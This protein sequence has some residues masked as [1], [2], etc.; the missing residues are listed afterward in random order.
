MPSITAT[1]YGICRTLVLPAIFAFALVAAVLAA[2]NPQQ[3][4]RA[5]F[6]HTE[7]RRPLIFIPGLLGSRLCRP[8]PANPAEP[9]V[10]W[11]T[12]GA[13]SQFPTIRLPSTPSETDIKPCGLIRE[14]VY[15]G[16]FTQQVYGPV[17]AHF[18]SLGYREGENLFVFDYDWRR[19]VFENAELL[20]AFVQDKVPEDTRV[21]IV[22][23]SMGG[24][25][26]RVYALKHNGAPWLGR[27]ISAGTPFQGSVTVFATLE[28]GWGAMNY[29][30]GGLK[31]FRQT[32]LSFPSIF[33]LMPSYGGCC[34]VDDGET[35]TFALANLQSW[36]ELG[37][38]GIDEGAL[39]DL[40]EA[41]ARK[42]ELHEI[43]EAGLPPDVENIMLIGVDQRTP[44]RFAFEAGW[45]TRVQ[46][47]LETTWAGD[48]T[49]VRESAVMPRAV[50]HPTSFSDHEH[51]L[52]DPQ[53][54][55]FL[56]I[57]LTR[58]LDAAI[59]TVPVRPRSR[60]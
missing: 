9:V 47:R 3:G 42:R 28:R 32:V 15:L 29:L 60:I 7:A 37:W 16:L 20:A 34:E 50:V 57:V 21:D 53:V 23:H 49:V 6:E 43:A 2:T 51:I 27:L 52:H 39:P 46:V 1:F 4:A 56:G 10:V 5:E 31:A 45:W 55:E 17:I 24:L 8:D 22:A 11:G 30:M 13:L 12:L 54:Q 38:D 41:S 19:S 40:A 25:I 36:L 59:R 14:I 18:E 48:G 33:E 35:S 26:A 44:Q 58:G